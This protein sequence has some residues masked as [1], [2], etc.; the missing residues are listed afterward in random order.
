MDDNFLGG[1]RYEQGHRPSCLDRREESQS[2]NLAEAAA[3][4][5]RGQASSPSGS[6][7][8]AGVAQWPVHKGDERGRQRQLINK[9]RIKADIDRDVQSR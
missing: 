2:R 9:H 4:K 7:P 1:H 8:G 6:L 3:E 5:I